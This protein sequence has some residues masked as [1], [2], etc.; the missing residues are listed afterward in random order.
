MDPIKSVAFIGAGNMGAPMARCALRAG[1]ALTICDRNPAVRDAFAAQGVRTT[2]DVA[3]C[4]AAD[5][6]IVLLANDAQI[7]EAMLGERGLAQAIPAGHHPL[8]CM[9][10]TTLPSTL[11]ALE[12]PLAAA[13]ACLLDAPI[14][15]GIVGAQD[16]TLTIML[17]GSQK[18]VLRAQPLMQAMG[19]GIF[20]C[21]ALGS[22]AV[23][24]IINNMLCVTNMFLA[25]EAVELA[26]AHGVDF[27]HLAPVLEVST[28][29]NFLT[30]DATAGRAQYRAW[31]PTEAAFADI[32]RIISKD[33]HLAMALGDAASLDLGMLKQVSGF[34]DEH[35]GQAGARWKRAGEP[36]HTE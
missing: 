22:A 32:H 21:G 33:L 17:G 20:H 11:R 6:I 16:G 12:A 18:D 19:K 29:L 3:D 36:P 13:G 10:S 31:V 7:T 5:A 35:G 8:V 26:A 24:K 23:T 4:A 34:V 27:E 15:G 9:M 2:A 30:A 28:G 1:Y 14:S 25:A